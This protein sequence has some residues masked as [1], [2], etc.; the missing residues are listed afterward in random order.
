MSFC[1]M[2]GS[3]A[4]SLTSLSVSLTST[5]GQPADQAFE[6]AG[7]VKVVSDAGAGAGEFQ[8]ALDLPPLNV[9]L[10]AGGNL[11]GNV[12]LRHTLRDRAHGPKLGDVPLLVSELGER[13]GVIGRRHLIRSYGP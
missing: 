11:S 6:N 2:P 10:T 9:S 3:S 1:S 5:C 8:L 12:A 4:T 13:A 7:Y